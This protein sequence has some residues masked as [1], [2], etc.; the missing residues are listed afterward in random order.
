MI[1]NSETLRNPKTI[2]W[3]LIANF[4]IGLI[5]AFILIIFPDAFLSFVDWPISDPDE[6]ALF[7][8]R[9]LGITILGPSFAS[10]EVATRKDKWKEISVIMGIECFLLLAV[11][12]MMLVGGHLIFLL[13][14]SLGTVFIDLMLVFLLIIFTVLT[15]IE[16]EFAMGMGPP[17]NDG[18]YGDDEKKKKTNLRWKRKKKTKN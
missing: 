7:V 15:K 12:L 11:I 17:P 9:M 8:Y 6:P 16:W 14:L 10:F 18:P 3:L 13:P 2:Y 4:V 5:F 1:K